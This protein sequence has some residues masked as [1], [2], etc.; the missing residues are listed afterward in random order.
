MDVKMK[1]GTEH[2]VEMQ[3]RRKI[4]KNKRMENPSVR[5]DMHS[6]REGMRR[7]VG[8]E[9]GGRTGKTNG[10]RHSQCTSRKESRGKMGLC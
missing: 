2:G 10:G 4:Q 6:G 1:V 3:R 5:T 9:E 8:R 7:L